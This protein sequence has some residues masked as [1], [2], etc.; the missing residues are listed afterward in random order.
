MLKMKWFLKKESAGR[1][2]QWGK[3]IHFVHRGRTWIQVMQQKWE[4]AKR[5]IFLREAAKSTALETPWFGPSETDFL[6]FG[7]P[8]LYKNKYVQF[9]VT[10]IGNLLE[11]QKET[12]EVNT[13][14]AAESGA[15]AWTRPTY[16]VSRC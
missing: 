7:S 15:L 2:L 1:D 11:Q 4:N 13:A 6:D 12:N 16:T 8:E 5:R 10:V 14:W 3:N 9:S